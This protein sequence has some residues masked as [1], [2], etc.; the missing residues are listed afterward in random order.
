MESVVSARL[1]ASRTSTPK[2]T[3]DTNLYIDAF[4]NPIAEASVDAFLERAAPQTHLSAVVVQ[5]LRAG[6]RTTA[7]AEALQRMIF[8]VFER[9]DRLFG[10]SPDAFKECGRIL[11]ALW[12]KDGVPFRDRPR[13]LVNDIL[14]AAS[15]RE[16][17]I[18]LITADR[19]Y[20]QIAPFLRGFRVVQ[21]WPT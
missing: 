5:E 12:R 16:R 1:A 18:T 7:Q 3:L 2:Y 6:A 9:R 14:L 17:G 15:C 21:P 11:A 20:R 8:A 4:A 10:P 19:D 13:S